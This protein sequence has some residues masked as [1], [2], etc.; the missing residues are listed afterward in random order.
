MVQEIK[1]HQWLSKVVENTEELVEIS[2]QLDSICQYCDLTSPIVCVERCKIWEA[3]KEFMKMRGILCADEHVHNLLNAA[4]ND[5]RQRVIEALYERPRSI[6]GLQEYLK[7]KGYYHSRGT[8]VSEYVEPLVD[9]GIVKAESDK[10]ELTVYGR[11]FKKVLDEFNLENSLPSHSRCYEEIILTKLK[12]GPKTYTDLSESVVQKSLSRAMK[13][14]TEKGMVNKSKTRDYIFYFRT[15]KVPKKAFS[16]TEK[17]VYETIP[18]VGASARELSKNIG[19][20]LRRIYKYLRRLRKKRLV[21]TR[22]RPRT[23][24]LTPSGRDVAAFIE[25]TA[26]LVLDASR[27]SDFLLERSQ[28]TMATPIP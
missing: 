17:K 3:K 19:I 28:K 10:Y 5:R 12:D 25:E 27:A 23:Y 2:K 8:I 6:K 18:E 4:K 20:N 24:E 13:R 11:K 7:N 22:K 26:S 1:S 14:L 15:K 16:P 21:F 9:V